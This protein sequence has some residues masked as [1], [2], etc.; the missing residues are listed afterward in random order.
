MQT[1]EVYARVHLNIFKLDLHFK[2][3]ILF[4][5]FTAQKQF[6]KPITQSQNGGKK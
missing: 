1:R 4:G 5:N 6:R 2:K 3:L